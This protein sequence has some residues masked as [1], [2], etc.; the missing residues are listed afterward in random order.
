MAMSSAA[1]FESLVAQLPAGS[2]AAWRD[3]SESGVLRIFGVKDAL[4]VFSLTK[5]F[6]AAAILRLMDA[7]ALRVTDKIAK[8]L[9]GAPGHG[10]I[11][12]VLNHTAGL[13]DYAHTPAYLR[14]VHEQPGQPWDLRQ[15][16]SISSTGIPGS[17][18]YSN[19]GYWLLGALLESLLAEPLHLVLEREVFT[20]LGMVST[21]YPLPETSLSPSG[22]S[23][24][25]AGPAGAA[26][27]TPSDVLRFQAI[28]Q[29]TTGVSGD[30]LS[31]AARELLFSCVAVDA[32]A[33]WRA[34]KYA[35]GIM[36]DPAL[37]LWGHGGSGPGYRS[38]AF[39][40]LATG[41]G[42]SIICP[43]S[44]T[45]NPE[46]ILIKH[47]GVQERLVVHLEPAHGRRWP[48]WDPASGREIDPHRLGLDP[49]LIAD[50][51]SWAEGWES[52]NSDQHGWISKKSRL[53]FEAQRL[54]LLASLRERA[55]GYLLVL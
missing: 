51:R 8:F 47:L 25:W 26:F 40:S 52:G 24:L 15:I 2:A 9:P 31:V 34:P 10:S 6:I 48:L 45:L 28:L 32:Q 1:A 37:R 5:M 20:P 42:A 7:G 53:G 36:V 3:P 35:M 14:A 23:T 41:V 27:S 46:A 16:A 30:Y 44:G 18:A 54:V 55:G 33:P 11:K 43:S 50:L 17:F 49:E 38:A 12:A 22:Y 19:T 4:P 29:S 13:G 21:R 39:S